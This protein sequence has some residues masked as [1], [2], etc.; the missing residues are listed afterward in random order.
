MTNGMIA[1]QG[2]FLGLL[3]LE[4]QG[5]GKTAL[6]QQSGT[7]PPPTR[8]ETQ[9]LS[10]SKLHFITRSNKVINAVKSS[11]VNMKEICWKGPT[12]IQREQP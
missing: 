8:C 9:Q 12:L 10:L 4:M 5:L 1:L 11:I 7:L 2:S 3:R 6:Q